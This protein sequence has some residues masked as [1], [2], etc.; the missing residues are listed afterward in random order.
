MKYARICVSINGYAIVGGETNEEILEHAKKLRR[1][2]LDWEPVNEDVMA[3]ACIV[4]E[5]GPLGESLQGNG[6]DI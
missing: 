4:E 5:C 3:D 2:D 1:E 6:G